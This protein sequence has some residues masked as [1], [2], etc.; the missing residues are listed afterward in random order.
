MNRFSLVG[1]GV[2]MLLALV[3]QAQRTRAGGEPVAVQADPNLV[4]WWKLDEAAGTIVKDSSGNGINGTF[5][6][7]PQTI[8]MPPRV[9]IGLAL[10]SNADEVTTAGFS[11]VAVTGGA[12]G[13]WET[14]SIGVKQP[15]N[16]PDD[17]SVAVEDS[18]G[19]AVTVIHPDPTAVNGLTWTGWKIPLGDVRG[20]DLARIRKMHIGVGRR[21]TPMPE[22]TGRIYIDDI[23]LVN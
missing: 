1:L 22:G 11:H 7:N 18:T 15:G 12:G 20:L 13:A 2:V 16:S 6:G 23:R 10:T 9:Y 4:G 19:A 5:V 3:T 21:D 14:A 8:D 17:L